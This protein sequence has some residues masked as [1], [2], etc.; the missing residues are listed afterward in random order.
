MVGRR[1]ESHQPGGGA[2]AVPIDGRAHPADRKRARAP[3]SDEA[4]DED[5]EPA[6]FAEELFSRV[7]EA[8]A[9]FEEEMAIAAVSA[10][11]DQAGT[12]FAEYPA[13]VTGLRKDAAGLS[14]AEVKERL[15]ALSTRHGLTFPEAELELLAHQLK[16]ERW[17]LHRP[18]QAVAWVW[19][20]RHSAP[21]STRLRQLWSGTVW[22]IRARRR[23]QDRQSA[24][25]SAGPDVLACQ[26]RQSSR[27]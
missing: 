16:D 10:D 5:W 27:T 12:V 17:R 26:L 3:K 25:S 14:S 18:L 8:D 21:L 9:E 24:T 15:R 22:F 19:R 13:A 11:H 23:W 20:N 2:T 4:P 6:E 1:A 7:A